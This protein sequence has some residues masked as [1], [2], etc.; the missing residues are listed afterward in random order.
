M[1]RSGP[2]ATQGRPSTPKSLRVA[3]PAGC[4]ACRLRQRARRLVRPSR[5]WL[6]S[7]KYP[8]PVYYFISVQP[9]FAV[10]GIFGLVMDGP[11]LKTKNFSA[12]LV[13]FR[14]KMC[15]YTPRSEELAV[16]GRHEVSVGGR[17]SR[18]ALFSRV[19]QKQPVPFPDRGRSGR[20]H[21]PSRCP[22]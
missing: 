10:L 15:G 2:E 13:P 12:R 11:T 3:S 18:M 5:E 1:V 19:K 22:C 6:T 8:S 4:S 14:P 21:T 20:R 7:P 16:A 17:R 9:E